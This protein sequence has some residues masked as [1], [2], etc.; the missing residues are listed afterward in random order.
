M[1][2][3]RQGETSSYFASRSFMQPLTDFSDLIEVSFASYQLLSY[4]SSHNTGR[5]CLSLAEFEYFPAEVMG[6]LKLRVFQCC[7]S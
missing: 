6:D 2:Q 4:D 3:I 7:H 5:L 1:L